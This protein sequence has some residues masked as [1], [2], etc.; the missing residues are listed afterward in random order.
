MCFSELV[1]HTSAFLAFF[2]K[3]ASNL[4]RPFIKRQFLF[5]N[6]EF[7]G[8]EKCQNTVACLELSF[9]SCFKL[10]LNLVVRCI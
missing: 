5:S 7:W 8:P 4:F 10:A 2:T 9:L 3:S 1:T 6:L